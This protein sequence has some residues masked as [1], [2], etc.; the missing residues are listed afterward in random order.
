MSWGDNTRNP[1]PDWSMSAALE[2]VP[3]GDSELP[4]VTNLREAVTTWQQLDR[5]MRDAAILMLERPILLDGA[6]INRF[7]GQAIGR[8]ADKLPSQSEEQ[9]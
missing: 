2:N 7:E 9:G 5:G 6:Q 8:L 4:E 1:E 3:R